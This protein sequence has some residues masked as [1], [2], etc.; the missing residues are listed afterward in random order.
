MDCDDL[1]KQLNEYVDG[2]LAPGVCDEFRA[3]LKDCNPC[4][5]VVDNVR[6]TIR[7]YRDG[8]EVPLP[9]EC[10]AKLHELLKARFQAKFAGKSGR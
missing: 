5:V 9:E 8:Q 2:N 6:N 1:L 4:Q 7:L 10:R 3:H